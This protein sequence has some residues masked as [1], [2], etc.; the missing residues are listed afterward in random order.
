MSNAMVLL[1]Q[2]ELSRAKLQQIIVLCQ[3]C[4]DDDPLIYGLCYTN[5]FAKVGR[6]VRQLRNANC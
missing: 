5:T 3:A 6:A 1:I 4:Y 2:D